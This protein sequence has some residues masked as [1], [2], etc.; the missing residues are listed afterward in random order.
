MKRVILIFVAIMLTSSVAFSQKREKRE[1][2]NSEQRGGNPEQMIEREMATITEAV[3]VTEGEAEQIKAIL[4]EQQAQMQE[5][6]SSGDRESGREKM[7]EMRSETEAKIVEVLGQER[8]EIYKEAAKNSRPEGG[9]GGQ[10][11]PGG[12]GQRS[13]SGMGMDMD[14]GGMGMDF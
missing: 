7:Q 5:M 11:G 4:L 3:E 8:G 12:R 9:P 10:G 13:D 14:M 1:R 6:M 2:N